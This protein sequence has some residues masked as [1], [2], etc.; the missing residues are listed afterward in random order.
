RVDTVV[1]EVEESDVLMVK[2][3][4]HRVDAA[5]EHRDRRALA[6]ESE[7]LI[8]EERSR[9]DVGAESLLEDGAIA[10]HEAHETA[11]REIGKLRIGNVED[12]RVDAVESIADGVLLEI[13]RQRLTRGERDD[14]ASVAAGSRR[15]DR[16]IRIEL[17]VRSASQRSGSQQ[18]NRERR[19][20]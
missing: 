13:R 12:L 11:R 16:Q 18:R 7:V 14:H 6:G 19:E 15:S 10:A 20:K 8:D 4:V 17:R 2:V 1:H 9:T 3:V 5:V